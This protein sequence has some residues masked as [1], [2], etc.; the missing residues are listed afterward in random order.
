MVIQSLDL[1]EDKGNFG[2]E[3]QGLTGVCR[4]WSGRR[5]TAETMEEG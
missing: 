5:E 2:V 3:G 1:I 4:A